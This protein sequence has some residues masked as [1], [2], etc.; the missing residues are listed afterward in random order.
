MSP[1]PPDLA[2]AIRDEDLTEVHRTTRLV[3]IFA[4]GGRHPQRWSSFRTVGPL[5]HGTFDT[6]PR[7]EDG[8]PNRDNEQGVLYFALS[9]RTSVGEVFRS[10]SAVDRQTRSPHL[11]MLRP[12]RALRLLDLT[13]PWPARFGASPDLSHAE[14]EV[15]QAWARAIREAAPELDG[16]WYRSNLDSG[17]PAICL[18]DPPAASVLPPAPDVLLP[19]AHQG[20]TGQLA[21]ACEELGYELL[22]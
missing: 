16:L 13:G 3:R 11:V 17:D 19:L 14:P 10:H 20:L 4:A 5:P 15:T 22:D 7:S 9:L 1:L 6:Q 21:Q 8:A 2:G 18:W 12:K